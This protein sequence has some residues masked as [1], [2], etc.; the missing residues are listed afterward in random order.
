MIWKSAKPGCFKSIKIDSLPVQYYSQ[1]N[2]WMTADILESVLSKFNRRLRSQGQS[3]VLLMD[4]AGCHPE[5]R[6]KDCFGNIRILF[7]PP[8]T[9]SK[10]QPLDLGII[11]NFKVHNRTPF[12]R[13]VSSKIDNCETATEVTKSVTILQAIR[14]IAQ[15]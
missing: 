2:A 10:L 15:R 6:L 1:P 12:L 7:L 3:I 14:W 8:N 9:T 11:Q 13:F 5:E 4:N